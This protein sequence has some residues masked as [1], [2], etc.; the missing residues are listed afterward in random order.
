MVI[1]HSVLFE[2]ESN[3]GSPSERKN[4]AYHKSHLTIKEEQNVQF[5]LDNFQKKN[6]SG[7]Q[8]FISL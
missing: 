6:N 8:Y 5:V 3:G 7:S 4:M 2:T 1:R